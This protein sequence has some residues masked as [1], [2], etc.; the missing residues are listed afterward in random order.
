MQKLLADEWRQ[1]GDSGTEFRM[2]KE[3]DDRAEEAEA[4]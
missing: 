1:P 4:K 2:E 3:G